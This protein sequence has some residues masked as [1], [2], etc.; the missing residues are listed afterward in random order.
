MRVAARLALTEPSSLRN[1]VY[2]C[3]LAWGLRR[4]PVMKKRKSGA[5]A[6]KRVGAGAHLSTRFLFEP[7]PVEAPGPRFNT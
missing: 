3:V 6:M 2:I 5:H 1:V 7:A 4:I